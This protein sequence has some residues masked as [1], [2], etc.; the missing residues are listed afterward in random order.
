MALDADPNLA[1]K[2]QIRG[3]I[4]DGSSRRVSA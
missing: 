3:A 4:L 2:E 1:V